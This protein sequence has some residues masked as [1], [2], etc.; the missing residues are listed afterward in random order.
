MEIDTQQILGIYNETLYVHNL[1]A[2]LPELQGAFTKSI[3]LFKNAQDINDECETLLHNMLKA[4]GVTIDD[5][6][7]AII[8]NPTQ[9]LDLIN[10]YEPKIVLSFGIYIANEVYKMVPRINEVQQI[11]GANAIITMPLHRLINDAAAKKLL[12]AGLQ[13]VF[14]V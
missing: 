8:T 6:Y 10:K 2:D 9:T 14:G 3:L 11:N 5:C 13:K 1:Q 4:C 7:S 12:W